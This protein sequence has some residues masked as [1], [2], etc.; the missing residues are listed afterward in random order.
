MTA[1]EQVAPQPHPPKLRPALVRVHR[2]AGLG[3]GLYV[4]LMSLSGSAVVFR[5][6][7]DQTF[8]PR[9]IM[10]EPSGPRMTH[11]QLQAAARSAFP[12]FHVEQIEIREPRVPGAA[13]EV[14]LI[15]GTRR[16]DRL[17]N[18]YTGANL[19]DT[20]A[21]EPRV[22]GWVTDLHDNLRAGDT[23]RLLNGLGAISMTLIGVTGAVIW[24]PG[25]ARWRR[26]LTLRRN[27]SWR[28]FMW[29]LHSVL[30]FWILPFFLMWAVTGIY[31]AFPDP[32]QAVAES[33]VVGGA[34]TS[35]SLS[36]QDAIAGIVRLHFGRSYGA[37]IEVSWVVL[38]LVPC[39]LFVTGLI[40]WWNRVL[41]QSA[42]QDVPEK[43]ARDEQRFG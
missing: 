3:I 39:G 34:G 43:A 32:F 11:E 10:V 25:R 19:G 17:F 28:Q 6:E 4:V 36:F 33:F 30:G 20:V 31:F 1:A 12:R 8:C 7:L 41:R 21:C 37:F 27:V 29:D 23:G 13:T 40:V 14:W 5:R 2:W 16:I 24:W 18:P 35:L 26:R 42:H 15:G 22:V 9:I 38:G